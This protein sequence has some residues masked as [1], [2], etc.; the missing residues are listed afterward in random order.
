MQDA[1]RNPCNQAL[2]DGLAELQLPD[3]W[4]VGGCLFQTVWNLLDGRA[5]GAG[6]RDYDVF[7]FDPLDLSGEAEQAVNRQAQALFSGLDVQ[8]DVR[9]QARVHTWYPAYFGRPCLP[10]KNA[11]E[12][13]DRFL[14]GSTS[15]GLR[16]EA[17]YIQVYAP[18]GLDDMYRGILSPNPRV[19]HGPLYENK[20]RDYQARWQWL[21]RPDPAPLAA[22]FNN[23]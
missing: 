6:I 14:V 13:V 1:L 23:L 7:Y 22:A 5:P 19:D 15:V 12:G 9:N 17:G 16:R 2:L 18:Y 11:C 20:V 3:A 4:L 21:S 8:L 10:L